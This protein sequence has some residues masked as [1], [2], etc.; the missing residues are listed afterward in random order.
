MAKEEFKVMTECSNCPVTI[1]AG[2]MKKDASGNGWVCPDC[3]ETVDHPL[4][5][6]TETR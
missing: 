3:Y 4:Y 6:R 2:M 5:S 1:L